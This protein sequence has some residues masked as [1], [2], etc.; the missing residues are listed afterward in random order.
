M[1]TL[2]LTGTVLARTTR[3]QT[4]RRTV[5]ASLATIAVIVGITSW[6]AYGQADLAMTML[7]SLLS[8][9]RFSV[10]DIEMLRILSAVF[11]PSIVGLLLAFF[12][13]GLRDDGNQ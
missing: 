8:V 4:R 10:A 2:A 7:Q 5:F 3:A 1:I 12:G 6:F 9:H 13:A 11:A